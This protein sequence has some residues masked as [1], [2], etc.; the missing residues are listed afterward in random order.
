MGQADQRHRCATLEVVVGPGQL[1]HAV[2]VLDGRVGVA[3]QERKSGSVHGSHRRQTSVCHVVEDDRGVRPLEP[4]VDDLEQRV[5]RVRVAGRHAG[6]DEC[7]GEHR[8]V[9]VDVVGEG[10]EPG[11]QLRLVARPLHRGRSEFDQLRSSLNVV[12]RERVSDRF[13]RV[14]VAGVPVARPA[15]QFCHPVGL[16]VEKSRPDDIAEEMVVPIPGAAVVERNEEQVRSIQLVEDGLGVVLAG[17]R[18]A[19]RAGEPAEIDVS[20]RKSRMR[21]VWRSRTSS[22][23]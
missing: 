17:H 16:L 19:E 22:A 13:V 6:T 7:H 4:G 9:L 5:E 2:R 14:T 12:A 20:R 8:S 23:R 18:R 3:C 10:F 1:E 15:V 11:P 21:A